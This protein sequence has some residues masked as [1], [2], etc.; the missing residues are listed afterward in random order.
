MLLIVPC[1]TFLYLINKFIIFVSQDKVIPSY[2]INILVNVTYISVLIIKNFKP[3]HD[4]AELIMSLL[5]AFYII[6]TQKIFTEDFTLQ[7]RLTYIPHH[8]ITIA[9]IMGQAYNLYPL[10]IGMWYLTMFEFSNFF[11]QFFQLFHKKNWKTAR[12]IITYPF[13]LT[14]VPIRGIIIP[15]YS[16]NFIPHIMVM[17][18]MNMF[19]FSYLFTFVDIFSV[20]F[21]WVVLTKFVEHHKKNN[22]NH[23]KLK[24]I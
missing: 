21:A 12:N 19:L 11:L 20:Y 22:H 16:L 3:T 15:I 17:S 24:T 4:V 2:F 5:I 9:L 7:D 1:Y 10:E 13:A 8:I 6:D 23:L 18:K 14:Y